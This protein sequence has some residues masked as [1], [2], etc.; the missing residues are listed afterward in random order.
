MTKYFRD[1]IIL[2]LEKVGFHLQA[3]AGSYPNLAIAFWCVVLC[4]AQQCVPFLSPF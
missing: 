1:K 2:V 3:L 4:W